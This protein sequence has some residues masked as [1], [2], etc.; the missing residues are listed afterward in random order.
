MRINR[1]PQG[2][3]D[4]EPGDMV[5][6]TAGD[7]DGVWAEVAVADGEP[8]KTPSWIPGGASPAMY[9]G[10]VG[11]G[12]SGRREAQILHEGRILNVLTTYLKPD[13]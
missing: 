6:I 1:W 13:V 8:E 4:L 7:L 9:I 10:P 2:G 3:F 5:R 12:D 11:E